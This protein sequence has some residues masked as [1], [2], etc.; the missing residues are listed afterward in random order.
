MPCLEYIKYVTKQMLYTYIF[1]L[2]VYR[3]SLLMNHYNKSLCKPK[4][5]LVPDCT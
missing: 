5:L 4:K 2:N 1:N 3:D